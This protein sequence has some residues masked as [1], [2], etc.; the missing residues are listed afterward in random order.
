MQRAYKF[1]SHQLHGDVFCVHFQHSMVADDEVEE[2]GAELGRL[3]D[4]D[5]CRKMIVNLGASDPD[6]IYQQFPERQL[7][8]SQLP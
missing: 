8:A 6:L 7:R 1:I 3:I 2:L 4:E 5:S